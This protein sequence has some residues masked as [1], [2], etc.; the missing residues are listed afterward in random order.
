[1]YAGGR[2]AVQCLLATGQSPRWFQLPGRVLT[3]LRRLATL[4]RHWG[5]SSLTLRLGW[6]SLIIW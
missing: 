5:H 6:R 2:V 3:W 1:M 4:S